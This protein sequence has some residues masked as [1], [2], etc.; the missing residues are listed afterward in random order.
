[1][2]WWFIAYVVGTLAVTAAFSNYVNR[3]P[4]IGPQTLAYRV[5]YVTVGTAAL[6]L[7]PVVLSVIIPIVWLQRLRNR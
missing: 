5:S 6:L 4:K 3:Q 2:S 7:W 1:M